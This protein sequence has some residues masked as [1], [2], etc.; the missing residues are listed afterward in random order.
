VKSLLLIRH[1]KSSWDSPAN[2]DRE[3][4]LN[5]RGRS[6]VPLIAS[7]LKRRG[8]LP[9][10]ILASD[11]VRAWQTAQ[12]LTSGMGLPAHS[13]QKDARIYLSDSNH[14]QAIIRGIPDSHA[15]VFVVG[16]NPT[17]GECA[18]SLSGEDL[19]HLPTCGVFAIDLPV[20]S[21]SKIRPGIG[22]KRFFIAPKLL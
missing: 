13:I 22:T 1:A 4:P 20:E 15:V 17:I 11:A 12:L 10:L 3:R 8:I 18:A 5:E 6:D 7:E 19:D 2:S 21:W 14:L 9:D 16:H